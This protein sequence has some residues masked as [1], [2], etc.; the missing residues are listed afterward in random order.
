M[1]V[2]WGYKG[3]VLHHHHSLRRARGLLRRLPVRSQY[4]LVSAPRSRGSL[5]VLRSPT[6]PDGT[7][8]KG[9]RKCFFVFL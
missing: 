9:K 2:F 8:V 3:L 5:G 7:P 4:A 1:G 6:P